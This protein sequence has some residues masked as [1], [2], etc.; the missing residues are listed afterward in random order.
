MLFKTQ[1]ETPQRSLNWI[2]DSSQLD[3]IWKK[4]FEEDVLIFKHSTRCGISDMAFSRL[5]DDS[6][7]QSHPELY[8]LDLIAYRELSNHIE[9]ETGVPHQSPQMILLRNGKAIYNASHGMIRLSDFIE[10][11]KTR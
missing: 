3:K 1:K 2:K 9:D 10:Q 11:S 8:L 6:Q 4:S 5:Q 7:K